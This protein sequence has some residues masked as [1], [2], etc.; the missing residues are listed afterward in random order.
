MKPY[1]QD[2][3]AAIYHGDSHE[4]LPSLSGQYDFL[5]TDPPYGIDYDTTEGKHGH[6][7]DAKLIV[8]DAHP[9]DARSLDALKVLSII[10]GANCFAS[11]L[12]D[13]KGW[14]TWLKTAPS[15]VASHTTVFAAGVGGFSVVKEI[16]NCGVRLRKADME[17]AWTNFLRR[18]QAYMM[19]WIG[20]AFDSTEG[21]RGN[22][23][24]HPTCKPFEL[25]T[26]CLNLAPKTCSVVIDPYMGGGSTLVAASCLD[27]WKSIG[28]ELEERYCELAAKRLRLC[29]D[30]SPRNDTGATSPKCTR[31]ADF[32][33]SS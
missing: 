2:K 4:V 3:D 25:M 19:H 13:Q 18:P 20:A 21:R 26:W 6:A 12:S 17:L 29:G 10:W 23:Q 22:D 27:G 14:L 30:K 11:S 33:F 5:L 7:R 15:A 32:D 9:F 8:G 1:F 31:Q 16:S 24:H 28:I